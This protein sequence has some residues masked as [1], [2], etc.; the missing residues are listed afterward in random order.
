MTHVRLILGAIALAALA[1]PQ[2]RDVRTTFDLLKRGATLSASQAEK[3][4]QRL[5]R[6]PRDE[7]ARIQ[8]L[9]YYSAPPLDTPLSEV[10][11]AREKHILWIIENDPVEGLGLFQVGTGVYRLHCAGDGLA[12]SDAYQRAAQLWLA[13]VKAHPRDAHIRRQA[14]EALQFCSPDAAE[15]ILTEAGDV[16][17]LGALYAV[18]ALGVIGYS[19]M[20]NEPAGTDSSFRERPFAEKARQ[21]LDQTT[22][23]VLSSRAAVTLL[24]T[25]AILWADGKLDW[26]YTALGNSLLDKA[27][28]AR[29]DD[30][31]LLTAPT[32][33]PARG[34]RP[35][36]TVQV[37]GNVQAKKLTRK[38]VPEYPQAAR[39]LGVQGTVQLTAMVGLNGRILHLS[40]VSGPP[41][42]IP[43]SLEAVR[44]WEY[45]P[46]TLNGKPC[47]VITRIDVSFALGPR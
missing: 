4:E 16:A 8:L 43:A 23:A 9:A 40:P 13:K 20:N 27:R 24:R 21:I 34:E 3:L 17:G 15:Q 39:D 47:Y 42:L 2:G 35:P 29:P 1:F 12:D 30:F 10:K 31:W 14:V 28:V 26:D 25:G 37:G 36:V 44:Q 7:N 19:Y 33:L 45:Q 18:T 6:H 5:Q 11:R 46:T 41:E 22:D 38:V 32:V